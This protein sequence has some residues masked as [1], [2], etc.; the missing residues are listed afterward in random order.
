[1]YACIASVRSRARVP[2][3]ILPSQ[4]FLTPEAGDQAEMEEG[5]VFADLFPITP[6][7]PAQANSTARQEDV[8]LATRAELPDVPSTKHPERSPPAPMGDSKH[9]R[10]AKETEAMLKQ[11]LEGSL[12]RFTS[13]INS[14]LQEICRCVSSRELVTDEAGLQLRESPQAPGRAGEAGQGPGPG[15]G[16]RAG[17]DRRPGRE[18]PGPAAVGGGRGAGRAPQRPDRARQAGTFA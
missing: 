8:V 13:D 4:R 7:P 10:E 9:R 2:K 1:M 15:P 14:A 17:G 11:V 6:P 5:D 12:E 18:L 16:G 3:L